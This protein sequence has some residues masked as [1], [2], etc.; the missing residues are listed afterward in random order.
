[1]L[2]DPNRPAPQVKLDLPTPDLGGK[3]DPFESGVAFSGGQQVDYVAPTPVE[4]AEAPAMTSDG[5]QPRDPFAEP[6]AKAPAEAADPFATP[7]KKTA[8]TAPD[9]RRPPPA[10]ANPFG[11]DMPK[12]ELEGVERA[13]WSRHEY[14]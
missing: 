2:F 8:A 4:P 10:D 1:M 6:T 12:L 7:V 14:R 5:S 11:E 9:G 13:S 3:E